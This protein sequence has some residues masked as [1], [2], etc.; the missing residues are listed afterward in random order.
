M[1]QDH[2][3]PVDLLFL[4][5]RVC[6]TQ[7]CGCPLSLPENTSPLGLLVSFFS[8]LCPQDLVQ[9]LARAQGANGT[10]ENPALDTTLL[11]EFLGSDFDLGALQRQLPDTLPYSASD[12]YCTPQVKGARSRTPGPGAGKTRAPS[13]RSAAA[14][15]MPSARPLHGTAGEGDPG[16]AHGG[17]HNCYPNTG[18]PATPL[19]QCVSCPPGISGSYH[20][21]PL[22]HS[23]GVVKE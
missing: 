11:E 20:R 5:C 4:L 23:P 3:G 22:C 2:A 17:S 15:G 1:E 19:D 8:Q 10:L 16:Q 13:L 7:A 6:A 12:S 21:Q 18:H 14:P 9:C